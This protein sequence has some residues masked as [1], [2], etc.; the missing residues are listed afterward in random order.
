MTL[1]TC[2]LS[3]WN[4]NPIHPVL[5]QC[6]HCRNFRYFIA[7]GRAAFF[8]RGERR[9]GH[10]QLQ[11]SNWSV[12]PNCDA[13]LQSLRPE[14][15]QEKKR[16]ILHNAPQCNIFNQ[17]GRASA[18]AFKTKWHRGVWQYLHNAPSGLGPSSPPLFHF[19]WALIYARRA[20]TRPYA[21]AMAGAGPESLTVL[22]ALVPQPANTPALHWLWPHTP[23]SILN[24]N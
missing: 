1:A 18:A 12:G 17:E 10:A 9:R 24:Q 15:R 14:P 21:G 16:S 7:I 3:H 8:D 2:D 13:V 4:P 20:S 19:P 23:R 11:N 22:A 6:L 5:E